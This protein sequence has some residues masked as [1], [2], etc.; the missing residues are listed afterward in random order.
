MPTYLHDSFKS[1]SS[2][3]KPVHSSF[4]R[5]A[6]PCPLPLEADFT[7]STMS[8]LLRADR[9]VSPSKCSTPANTPLSQRS[10]STPLHSCAS[11]QL[12]LAEITPSHSPPTS[13][14]ASCLKRTVSL[15]IGHVTM[16]LREF[17]LDKVRNLLITMFMTQKYLLKHFFVNF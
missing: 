14:C 4:R 8:P 1:Y 10:S 7:L 12:S 3:N 11:S 9:S 16:P 15:T 13:L 17:V 5:T 2:H 6:L